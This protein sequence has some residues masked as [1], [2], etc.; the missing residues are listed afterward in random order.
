MGCNLF[1]DY[2][3]NAIKPAV[4]IELFHNFTLVHDDI[5]DKADT[6]RNHHTIHKKW[7]ENVAILSGDAMLIKSYEY[8]LSCPDNIVKKILVLFSEISLKVCEGQQYDM[9]FES[10]N[11]VSIDEYLKMIELKTAVLLAAS[12]KIG[13]IT[14]QASSDDA[15]LL[16]EF[17]R[18]VGIAFQLQ[19]DLLDVYAEPEVFGKAIGS[20]I[21]AN[22]KTFLLI[23]ALNCKDRNILS[24]LI[25][26]INR[27][28]FD[29]EKKIME[30]TAIFNKLGLV[31]ITKSKIADFLNKGLG[32]L[33]E[34]SV[35][36]VR[37]TNLRDLVQSM[38]S[39]VK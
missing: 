11:D 28:E 24:E 4:A 31:N 10:R 37:K 8:I 2:I 14:G 38:I 5:L 17:G 25:S 32:C 6:R 30:V 18:N 16:Y 33:D 23:S 19:D 13:A 22:K 39:R 3:D 34:I 9:N 1:S 7:N 27:K 20:D 21:T 26:W 35:P 12:S 29:K 15:E 36:D